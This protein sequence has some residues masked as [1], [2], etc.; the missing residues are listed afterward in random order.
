[1][2]RRHK[3]FVRFL[4]RTFGPVQPVRRPNGLTMYYKYGI[5]MASWDNGKPA[6]IGA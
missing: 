6:H 4:S 3:A 1:M 5:A 2:S